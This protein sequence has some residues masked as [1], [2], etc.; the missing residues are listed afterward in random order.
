[1][2]TKLAYEKYTS[3]CPYSRLQPNLKT[4]IT[5]YCCRSTKLWA[6]L[7]LW[8]N[9]MKRRGIKSSFVFEKLY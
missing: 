2:N 3:S 6:I 7:Y 9:G 1:M 4:G 5:A 8:R